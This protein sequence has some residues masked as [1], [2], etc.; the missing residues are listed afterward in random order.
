MT[1]YNYEKRDVLSYETE[2]FNDEY[3]GNTYK[4]RIAPSRFISLNSEYKGEKDKRKWG[5]TNYKNEEKDNLSIVL[6][7]K[8]HKKAE[9]EIGSLY[10][11][12]KKEVFDTIDTRTKVY[13]LNGELTQDI[14]SYLALYFL[15]GYKKKYGQDPYISLNDLSLNINIFSS[16]AGMIIRWNN[17]M[18]SE[19]GYRFEKSEGDDDNFID[20]IK[21]DLSINHRYIQFTIKSEFK[22]SVEPYYRTS[23]INANLRLKM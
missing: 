6:H 2:F 16:G 10:E 22:H 5:I 12:F 17:I 4:I 15:S 19:I 21:F 3:K 13:G 1:G 9:I 7:W 8:V 18:N 20:G 11:S 23:D 14:N